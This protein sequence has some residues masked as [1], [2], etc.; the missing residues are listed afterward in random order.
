MSDAINPYIAGN[1]V[2]GS[3]MFFGR[4]EVFE[5]VRQTLT[6]KHRDNVI[7][8]YGQRRT[9]KTSVL[10]QMRY[11]LDPRYLC[12][13]M[14]LHGF[15]L[16]S[17]GDFL[18]QLANHIVRVL[19][20][21]YQI[22]I[23][24]PNQTEFMADPRSSF[25]SEFL[26]QVWSHIGDHHILLMLDEAVRLEEQVRAGKLEQ[27]IFEY[28]RHLMQHYERLNF[29]FALGSGLEDMEKEYAFLF[30]VGL[31]KKISI[32]DR[33]AASTLITQP[34]KD[35]YHVE[36]A[37]LERILQ[38]TS[39]HPY[40]I[41]LLCHSLFNRWLQHPASH[42]NVRDVDEI[43]DEV[44]ERGLAVLKH[45]W[46]ESTPGEKAIMAGM[47]NVMD[48]SNRQVKANT[49]SQIWARSDVI[50]PKGEM[51]KAI[52]SLIG[53]DVIVGRDAYTF[54]VD[55]QRLWVQ[56]YRRL[57]WVREE[58]IG[59]SQEWR[60]T[61]PISR[62]I[63]VAGLVALLLALVFGGVF[64]WEQTHQQPKNL[65][66]HSA[67]T[68]TPI[69]TPTHAVT[70]TPGITLTSKGY[71]QLRSFYRGAAS[72][73]A[74][75]SLTFTLISE[76]QQGNIIIA[77]TFLRNDSTNQFESYSCKGSVT[78]DRKMNLHCN[79]ESNSIFLLD[80]HGNIYPDGHMEGTL[81]ATNATDPS[82]RHVYS[83]KVS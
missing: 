50:I 22:N 48:E 63:V 17:L 76:D 13:F 72:G 18:W 46:E 15:A 74:N 25:E 69:I 28:M 56:K 3:E 6:G 20:R 81:I 49:I 30:S 12:I 73:F 53:R 64:A 79:A 8:L 75:G 36:Q 33:N 1:P 5:F 7:V 2:T 70:P 78:K 59:S 44:V 35:L 41:Q 45:V 82:F 37:A 38:V 21:D 19:R 77:T 32:L 26:G 34:V 62:R 65:P 66:T 54:T 14:D 68:S 58:M 47:A 61:R 55:L 39:G 80:I 60:V 10:Y 40:Y 51:V 67:V 52:Q 42:I 83:W 29:L 27:N 24:H 11:H 9:G 23:Q 31:Y 16:E 4:E 43:L 57:E 71:V